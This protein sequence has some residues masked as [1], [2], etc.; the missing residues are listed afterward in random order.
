MQKSSDWYKITVRI[1]DEDVLVEIDTSERSCIAY[2]EYAGQ[3]VIATWA[4]LTDAIR[5]W[6]SEAENVGRPKVARA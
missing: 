1:G 2:G 3:I 5:K 6:T 4:T